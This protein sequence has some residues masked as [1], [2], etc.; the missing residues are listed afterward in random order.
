MASIRKFQCALR[1]RNLWLCARLQRDFAAAL[2]I[3]AAR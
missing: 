2:G 3:S 1:A